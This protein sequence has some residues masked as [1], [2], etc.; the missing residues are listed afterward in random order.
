MGG[1][2]VNTVEYYDYLC[3]CGCGGKIK[4]H[5]NHKYAG[6]PKFIHGHN[7]VGCV[8]TTEH[9]RKIGIANRGR[10]RPD[11]SGPN[12]PNK[13]IEIRKLRSAAAKGRARPDM[14]GD[15]NPMCRLDIWHDPSYIQKQIHSRKSIQNNAE[16]FLQHVLDLLFPNQWGFVGGWKLIIETTEGIKIP[17]FVHNSR[18]LLIELFGDYWHGQARTGISNEQHEQERIKLFKPCG[19]QTLIIWEHELENQE[20]LKQKL[21]AFCS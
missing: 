20:T 2:G 15:R 6:P 12:S 4:I 11:L 8:H 10:L 7:S 13:R 14:C 9:N 17:D 16:K 5:P 1:G 3:A 21:K 19:Y 18:F